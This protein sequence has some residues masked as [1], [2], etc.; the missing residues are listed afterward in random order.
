[1]GNTEQLT[2]KT[3]VYAITNNVNGKRYVGSTAVSFT[4][5]W[6]DHR[7]DLSR[8][9][10]D[11]SRLQRAWDKYGASAF[12]FIVLCVCEPNECINNEQ[13]WIDKCDSANRTSGYNLAPIAGSSLGRKHTE[14]GRAKIS[15]AKKGF[16]LSA[17][18]KAKLLAAN[19]GRVKTPQEIAKQ[20]S[21]V[22]GRK[23][24]DLH[25]KHLSQA[26]ATRVRSQD[27]TDKIAA[28]NRG[29]TRTEAQRGNISRGRSAAQLAALNQTTGA[30]DE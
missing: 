7:R 21:A 27:H 14:Q 11:N 16:Q 18:H 3:G 6:R 17:E 26:F 29:K 23:F 1:M 20:A 19:L 8:G 10:H 24:S 13:I 30:R 25:R 2:A 12:E 22:R 28:A 5:R 9:T 4:K 15:A